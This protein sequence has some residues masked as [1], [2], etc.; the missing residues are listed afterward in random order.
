M[1]DVG[2]D[3]VIAF[4]V[5]NGRVERDG[6]EV[7]GRCWWLLDENGVVPSV[8]TMDWRVSKTFLTR[9]LDKF[10]AKSIESKLW[11][12]RGREGWLVRILVPEGDDVVALL[13]DFIIA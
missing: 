6:G 11:L 7:G 13:K 2:K 9:V 1:I 4:G 3:N 5:G 10:S 8:P 12:K